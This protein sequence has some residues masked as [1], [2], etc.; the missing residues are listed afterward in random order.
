VRTMASCL[1][2]AADPWM[3]LLGSSG[4]AAACAALFQRTSDGV[5][6]ASCDSA[7]V[8]RTGT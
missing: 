1:R 4:A 5:A 3:S 8:A 6:P 7:S 2:Y